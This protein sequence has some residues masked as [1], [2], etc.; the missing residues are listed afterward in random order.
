MKKLAFEVDLGELTIKMRQSMGNILTKH[1]V[2]KIT[3]KE[4]GVSTLGGRKIW[5]DEDVLRLN[6]DNRGKYLGEFAGEDKILVI[7]KNG[8]SRFYNFDL[9]N[10]FRTDILQLKKFDRKKV[11]SEY[12]MI[13]ELE[14]STMLNVLTG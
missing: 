4:K 9:S 7:Y 2:Y 1:E 12:I 10:Q 13:L 11:L 3:L 8:N 14:I 6:A 5:F